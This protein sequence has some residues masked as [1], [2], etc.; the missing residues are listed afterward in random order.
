MPW[1][2]RSKA[3]VP[4]KEQR[5]RLLRDVVGAVL[6]VALVM[7]TAY[8]ASG[9]AWPPVIVVESGSMMH[10]Y[11]E[12]HYGRIGT[13]DVGELCSTQ[14]DIAVNDWVILQDDKQT[15]PADNIAPVVRNSYLNQV[16]KA[17]FQKLLDDVS[18]KIDTPTLAELYKEVSV[19]KKDLKDV[20][21]AWLKE[22]GLVK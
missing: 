16:D 19:D 7:G 2:G 15:Q 20:A 12:T 11:A 3:G 5:F 6:V 8:V 17:A 10:P 22:Q 14:P 9:G 13:I 4:R 1:F 21:S 18:A